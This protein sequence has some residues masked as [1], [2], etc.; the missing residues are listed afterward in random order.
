MRL[1]L[2]KIPSDSSVFTLLTLA[3]VIVF[4]AG[5]LGAQ[6][7]ADP[8]P[9]PSGATGSSVPALGGSPAPPNCTFCT[10]CGIGGAVGNIAGGG[11]AAG[12]QRGW[13]RH[14]PG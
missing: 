5:H 13:T 6:A 4:H 8:G 2:T 11:R 14:P 9:P 12:H 7:A 1:N 10:D 3:A